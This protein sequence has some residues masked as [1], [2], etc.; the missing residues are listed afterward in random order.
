M[1]SRHTLTTRYSNKCW[2]VVTQWRLVTEDIGDESSHID[3]SS[4]ICNSNRYIYILIHIYIYTYNWLLL[5][6]FIYL[7]LFTT[8][9]LF[10]FYFLITFNYSIQKLFLFQGTCPFQSHLFITLSTLYLTHLHT[11]CI[12][13][14]TLLT[15]HSP[16]FPN[17]SCFY[18]LNSF[19]KFFFLLHSYIFSLYSFINLFISHFLSSSYPSR[20]TLHP[21]NLLSF[22]FASIIHSSKLFKNGKN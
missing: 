6:L 12:Y 4:Q 20:D 14:Y 13:Y 3:D 7:L 16:I 17:H 5:L 10:Y 8:I 9:I 22:L 15:T 2:W 19:S 1:T 21:P 18:P 11:Y